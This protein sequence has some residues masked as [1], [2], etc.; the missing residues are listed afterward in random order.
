MWVEI[1]NG[2]FRN[3]GSLQLDSDMLLLL[4]FL[5]INAVMYYD[6]ENI[7]PLDLNDCSVLEKFV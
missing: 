5:R 3:I 2:G 7:E 4:R 6:H 1:P